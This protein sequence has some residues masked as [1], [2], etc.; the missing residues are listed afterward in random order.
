M[1][2]AIAGVVVKLPEPA[3][4]DG[5]P[6]VPKHW[7]KFAAD[8]E[9]VQGPLHIRAIP[10]PNPA[11]DPRTGGWSTPPGAG[12]TG[13]FRWHVDSLPDPAKYPGGWYWMGDVRVAGE[14]HAVAGDAWGTSPGTPVGPAWKSFYPYRPSVRGFDAAIPG[15]GQIRHPKGLHLNSH[16]VE[17]MWLDLGFSQVQPFTWIVVAAVMSD[18][19]PGYE[20][21]L[22]DGGRNPDE[23][24]FPRATVSSLARDRQ[25][26][27]NLPSRTSLFVVGDTALAMTKTGDAPL[28]AKGV[29]GAHPR[30]FA[31]VYS[32]G[33]S[34]L[35][36]FDA[37]GKYQQ[38]GSVSNGGDGSR[39]MVLGREH[40]WIGQAHASNILVFEVRYWRRALTE[41]EI[42][43]QYAQISSTHKFDSYKR[44]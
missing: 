3:I 34:R 33:E 31:S 2:R 14:S 22:L 16:Y 10:D 29:P 37:F 19:F 35:S 4:S 40:G 23:V 1:T 24:G 7:A 12:G 25:I 38:G 28:R 20:H 39:Y 5:Q 32:G 27:D 41:D 43:S 6:S 15:Q 9:L 26:G 18:P 17:H 30:M 36:M 21:R 44:L 8:A 42:G 13:D 11:W